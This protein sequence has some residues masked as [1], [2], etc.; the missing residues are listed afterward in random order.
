MTC[1]RAY[2]ANQLPNSWASCIALRFH[3]SVNSAPMIG[4]AAWRNSASHSLNRLELMPIRPHPRITSE[5]R[6]L[7]L[8]P[9][10]TI[11]QKYVKQAFSLPW[12]SLTLKRV[13]NA[14]WVF[15]SLKTAFTTN[16][17]WYKPIWSARFLLRSKSAMFDMEHSP[18][19]RIERTSYSTG[20]RPVDYERLHY[21]GDLVRFATRLV[22][23]VS[24]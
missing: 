6:S 5:S 24:C 14:G 15:I 10:R 18:I 9:P 12:L 11:H 20:G 13:A 16:A 21:R 17:M 22:R 1:C 8:L 19:F 2:L 7:N 4:S 3:A 23:K